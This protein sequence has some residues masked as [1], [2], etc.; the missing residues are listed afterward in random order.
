MSIIQGY[1]D[2][3]RTPEELLKSVDLVFQ[4]GFVYDVTLCE[5]S[6]FHVSRK[7]WVTWIGLEVPYFN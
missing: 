3:T 7:W 4:W 5:Q 2:I 1:D 6:S